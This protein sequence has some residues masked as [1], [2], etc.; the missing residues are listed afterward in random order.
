MVPIFINAL[1]FLVLFYY[2][3]PGGVL[4]HSWVA[5]GLC[6]SGALVWCFIPR[7]LRKILFVAIALPFCIGN[8]IIYG[9][10]YL[11]AE[12]LN[13]DFAISLLISNKSE[14]LGF[15]ENFSFIKL[16]GLFIWSFVP[17]M[18]VV[19]IQKTP[20]WSWKK[21]WWVLFPVF[22]SFIFC[23][24]A[25]WFY[26]VEYSSFYRAYRDIVKQ[27]TAYK[28]YKPK[29]IEGIKNLDFKSSKKLYVIVISDSVSRK[30]MSLYGEKIKTT[31]VLDM[32]KSELYVFNN[33]STQFNI[34]YKVL[35]RILNIRRNRE[36]I[37]LIDF[38]KNAGFK[39]YWFSAHPQYGFTNC[40]SYLAY[41][42]DESYFRR[43]EL[44]KTDKI[45]FPYFNKA[46]E[47]DVDNKVIFLHLQGS[48]NDYRCRIP[49]NYEND[50]ADF[51]SLLKN[52]ADE[53]YVNYLKSVKYG[54]EILG[55]IIQEVKAQKEYS[56]YVMYLSDHGEDIALDGKA[57]FCHGYINRK[58]VFEIPFILW[59]SDTYKN[60]NAAFTAEFHHYLF[61]PYS[62]K[63]LFYSIV[64]L[65][66]LRH[67]KI[68]EKR[69]IVSEK[70]KEVNYKYK[71][72]I[73][74]K[75]FEVNKGEK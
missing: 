11:L 41:N 68:D 42:A 35:S 46:L 43:N 50:N 18:G 37:N 71:N 57:C 28:N 5:L 55:Q 15:L 26:N 64:E 29:K 6:L 56:S 45:V 16:A 54:D 3:I 21:Y 20:N 60:N 49:K 4:E 58:E 22:G 52:G 9:S 23:W 70:Y 1:V 30:Y 53:R 10:K 27:E 67:D 69:S 47:D 31:P 34:T 44:D 59:L 25:Y 66:R 48:H 17:M 62:I 63:N 12:A 8:L 24:T 32:L 13:Y 65:S 19:V 40:F 75:L 74:H 61:R 14:A 2:G 73:K 38:F 39:V 33:V 72:N 7:Y 36:N 51:N